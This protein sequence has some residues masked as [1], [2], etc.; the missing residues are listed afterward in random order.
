M[1]KAETLRQ[2]FCGAGV[3]VIN[4][5]QWYFILSPE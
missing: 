1:G 3:W 5:L 2:L 4:E